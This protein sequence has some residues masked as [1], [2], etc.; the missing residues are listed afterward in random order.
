MKAS[1]ARPS[2]SQLHQ[3]LSA[4]KEM[5]PLYTERLDTQTDFELKRRSPLARKYDYD[6]TTVLLGEGREVFESAKQLIRGWKMFPAKWT[7]IYPQN[8]PIEV[9]QRVA[10]LFNL[11]GLW[12]WNSSEIQ[13]IIDDDRRFG[14]AYGT[15][16]GHLELGEEL[17]LVTIDEQQ[18]VWYKIKAFSRPAHFL[19][20]LAYPFARS[21]QR[22]FVRGSM[23]IMKR[24]SVK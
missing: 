3:Y 12:W 8:A 16:P 2:S 22:R 24:L 9:G 6:E 14:F 10:V 13:Y 5:S 1:F 20:R 23:A 15:L 21:Q 18:K 7:K 19:V 4:G 17:F 11:L